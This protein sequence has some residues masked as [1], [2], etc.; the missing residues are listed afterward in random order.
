MRFNRL[1]LITVFTLSASLAGAAPPPSPP[2][3]AVVPVT[4]DYFGAQVADDYRYFEDLKNPQVQAWM[5]GQAE[6]ARAVLDSLPG[7][8]RLLRY[9]LCLNPCSRA[10][11]IACAR[12]RTP[13]LSKRFEV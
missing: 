10:K 7:R 5:K 4:D 1:C 12:E 2:V 13:S 9:P 3:A 8:K 11:T 6:Y